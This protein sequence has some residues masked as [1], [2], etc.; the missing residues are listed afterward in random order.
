MKTNKIKVTFFGGYIHWMQATDK[1]IKKAGNVNKYVF[2]K[3]RNV[4]KIETRKTG[5][6]DPKYRYFELHYH[7]DYENWK[8]DGVRVETTNP[9]GHEDFTG[10]GNRTNGMKNRFYIGRST[11][12]LPIYLEILKSNSHGGGAMYLTKGRTFKALY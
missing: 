6:C 2:L 11:G 8:N 7:S 10:Y 4:H 9:S 12:W 3:L 1:K 5:R